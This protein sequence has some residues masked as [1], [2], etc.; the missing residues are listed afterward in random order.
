MSPDHLLKDCPDFKCFRC[1]ERGHFARDCNA[2]RCP[3]CQEILNKCECWREGEEGGRENQVDGQVHEGNNE[4]EG[5]TDEGQE[6]ENVQ[7]KEME[8]ETSNREEGESKKENETD[9][10]QTIEQ[11]TQWTM[12]ISESF[13]RYQD[14]VEKEGLQSEETE[15]EEEMTMDN[16][17]KDREG[18][19]QI[20]RRSLKVT[21]NLENA[22]K[23]TMT[24]GLEGENRE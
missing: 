16:M 22:R 20:R 24:R 11:D 14:D 13:K 8:G 1:G 9:K 2:A 18:R 4:E 12:E 19:G 21:P 10:E 15:S 17:D 7:Q 23:K 5:Q 3:E 6:E